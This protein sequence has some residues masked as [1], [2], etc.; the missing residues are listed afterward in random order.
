MIKE[1]M[2]W[3]K[4]RIKSHHRLQTA[5]DEIHCRCVSPEQDDEDIYC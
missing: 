2:I 1:E 3:T 4:R 5:D